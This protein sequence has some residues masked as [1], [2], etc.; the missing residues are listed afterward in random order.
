[1][2]LN[3]SYNCQ[4]AAHP[5]LRPAAIRPLSG[6]SMGARWSADRRLQAFSCE[7]TMHASGLTGLCAAARRPSAGKSGR[8]RFWELASAPQGYNDAR[9]R[10]HA[11][12]A[13]PLPAGPPLTP[14]LPPPL[15]RPS[16]TRRHTCS[17]AHPSTGGTD[18]GGF[19]GGN[20]G[21]SSGGNGGWP[22]GSGDGSEG[23]GGGW[24]TSLL[25][26]LNLLPAVGLLSLL[27][28]AGGSGAGGKRGQSTQGRLL[29]LFL[30]ASAAGSPA[31]AR[32][33]LWGF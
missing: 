18:G 16:R 12:A 28:P 23:S 31:L 3:T 21:G 26:F 2:Q 7:P 24:L 4:A 29:S 11:T 27:M 1:M 10:A 13:G 25:S 6:G 17:A 19:S 15:V 30:M 14:Y 33:A 8:G 32:L 20:N 9:L 22:G 5:A